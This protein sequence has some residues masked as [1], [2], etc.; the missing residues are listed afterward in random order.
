MFIETQS[1][2]AEYWSGWLIITDK[3]SHTTYPV[4]LRDTDTGRNITRQQF[5]SA[6][7]THGADRACR[8][9]CKLY[10]LPSTPC[11]S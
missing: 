11:Y 8:T 7:K 5:N 2:T 3:A 1:F 9:F 10:A 6:I 4:Q